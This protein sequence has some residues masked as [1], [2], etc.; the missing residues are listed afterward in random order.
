MV[1]TAKVDWPETARVAAIVG[2]SGRFLLRMSEPG[3]AAC[4]WSLGDVAWPGLDVSSILESWLQ[5]VELALVPLSR[6]GQMEGKSGSLVLI[7]RFWCPTERRPSHPLV[8]KSRDKKGKGVSLATEWAN[9]SAA[10]PHAYDRKD[11][12]AIPIH[13]DNADPDYE[14]L[15]SLCMPSVREIEAD[16]VDLQGFPE[17]QDLRTALA[18]AGAHDRNHDTTAL[19][20]LRQT[21]ASLRGLHR[22]NANLATGEF[23]Q[24]ERSWTEEYSWYLRSYSASGGG[25]WGPE[26]ASVWGDVDEK[27]T[28]GKINPI[29]L[30]E[31]LRTEHAPLK[32]GTV[33]GDLHPGNV[34]LR[35]DDSPAIIDFGWSKVRAHVAKDFALMECNLRFLTLPAQV[36]DLELDQFCS[37]LGFADD[38]PTMSSDRM[39]GRVQLV[40]AVRTAA[41]AVFGDGAEWDQQYLIPLFLVAFGLLRFAPQLGNQVAA[42][43]FVEALAN[44]IGTQLANA[45][46]QS[47][48]S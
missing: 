1:V 35:K 7:G 12:F 3:G 36:G 46:A 40:S 42:R 32:L 41:A 44:R 11:S 38:T 5:T 22:A 27:M 2:A 37:W 28:D 23:E 9:A 13:F 6:I 31:R 16:R 25:L 8:L 21:Y 39:T 48:P 26:W 15:W 30:V 14:I 10:K 4:I 33:H 47:T 45:A 43:R 24:E 34:L 17:V 19:Q 20:A 18:Y 29:W